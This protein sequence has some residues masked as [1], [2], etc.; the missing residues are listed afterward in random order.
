MSLRDGLL[1]FQE[2]LREQ[3]ATEP[4][5]GGTYCIFTEQSN[6]E[7]LATL[8]RSGASFALLKI[9][10]EDAM[11]LVREDQERARLKNNLPKPK[12][13][14]F[15]ARGDT[16]HRE[17]W[18]WMIKWPNKN[19]WR[20]RFDEPRA[21]YQIALDRVCE[22]IRKG[23]EKYPNLFRDPSKRPPVRIHNV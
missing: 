18:H 9:P 13:R 21:T 1:W 6:E 10:H 22:K 4:S 17:G 20:N 11:R 23:Y 3:L 7:L 12:I 15:Y 19:I 8:N 16:I 5:P 2:Q 14:I